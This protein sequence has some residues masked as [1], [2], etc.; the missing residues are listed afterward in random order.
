MHHGEKSNKIPFLDVMIK[1]TGTKILMDIHDKP[2]DSKRIVPYTL[3]HP[4]HCLTNTPCSL[5]RRVCTIAE[6][7]NVKIKRF[8]D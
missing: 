6:N 4:Q 3:N 1:K 5:A 8:K 7:E 2:T